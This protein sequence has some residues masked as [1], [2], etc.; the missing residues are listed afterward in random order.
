MSKEKLAE[1][2]TLI[3]RKQYDAARAILEDMPNDP[4]AQQWLTKLD[5][6]APRRTSVPPKTVKQSSGGGIINLLIAIV[7]VIILLILAGASGYFAGQSSGKEEGQ[8]GGRQTAA[9]EY[10]VAATQTRVALPPTLTTTPTPVLTNTMTFEEILTSLPPVPSATNTPRACN[11]TEIA[12][13]YTLAK[14]HI[15]MFFSYAETAS[16][17]RR[18]DLQESINQMLTASNYVLFTVPESRCDEEFSVSISVGMQFAADAYGQFAEDGNLTDLY[19]EIAT[20]RLAENYFRL[21]NLSIEAD[22][23]MRD[24]SQI[25]GGEQPNT[26]IMTATAA[27]NATSTASMDDVLMPTRRPTLPE[28]EGFKRTPSPE[29]EELH[30]VP[31]ALTLQP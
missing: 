24:T 20:Q 18:G 27:I 14:P 29:P 11:E 31:P 12:Q 10:A 7:V 25:W 19:F 6:I 17:T 30:G 8:K 2:R 16:R 22:V 9:Q 1:A 28:G 23:R 5:E 3:Q 21:I 15:E 13:W 4:T 26:R